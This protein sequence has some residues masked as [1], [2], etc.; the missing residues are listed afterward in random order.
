[1]QLL[2]YRDLAIT[3]GFI[4]ITVPITTAVVVAAIIVV[5][6]VVVIVFV[7]PR[8]LGCSRQATNAAEV[9]DGALKIRACHDFVLCFRDVWA[10]HA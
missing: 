5:V 2:G 3:V 4:I 10:Q 9:L 1:M 8:A 7:D 6:V